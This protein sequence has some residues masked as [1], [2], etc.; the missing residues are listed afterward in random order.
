MKLEFLI[1]ITFVIYTTNQPVCKDADSW[2]AIQ[3]EMRLT[4]LCIEGMGEF[5]PPYP[6]LLKLRQLLHLNQ[7]GVQH[8]ISNLTYAR[9]KSGTI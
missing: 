4:T 6:S 9:H 3:A 1:C 5:A 2:K 7:A 8:L